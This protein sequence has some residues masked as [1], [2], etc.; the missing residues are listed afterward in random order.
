MRCAEA[1]APRDR[2]IPHAT[3]MRTRAERT[4]PSARCRAPHHHLARRPSPARLGDSRCGRHRI[5]AICPSPSPPSRARHFRKCCS[6]VTR[7][8]LQRRRLRRSRRVFHGHRHASCPTVGIARPHARNRRS[9]SDFEVKLLMPS[10]TSGAGSDGS[11]AR[12][13]HPFPTG[14]SHKIQQD[15]AI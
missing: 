11:V 6:K 5:R 7:G 9:K 15:G 2:N 3:T 10:N 14:S 4:R 12:E 13:P 1:P 8:A